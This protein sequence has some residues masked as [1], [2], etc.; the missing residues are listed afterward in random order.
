MFSR[1]NIVQKN[2][3]QS[4]TTSYSADNPACLLSTKISGYAKKFA[5]IFQNKISQKQI[6]I[7]FKAKVVVNVKLINALKS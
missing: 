5:T 3:S 4:I 6:K 7:S 2:F 1:K